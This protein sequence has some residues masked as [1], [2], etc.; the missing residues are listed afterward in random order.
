MTPVSYKIR[1]LKQV[2]CH[3]CALS[4]FKGDAYREPYEQVYT[5][6]RVISWTQVRAAIYIYIENHI[7]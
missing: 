5:P 3:I 1:C 4:N 6:V 2:N 7:K